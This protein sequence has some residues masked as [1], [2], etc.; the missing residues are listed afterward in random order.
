[1]KWSTLKGAG[2]NAERQRRQKA[3]K[4]QKT[5]RKSSVHKASARKSMRKLSHKKTHAGSFM[6][7]ITGT[8][9]DHRRLLLSMIADETAAMKS[10]NRPTSDQLTKIIHSMNPSIM[11][12]SILPNPEQYDQEVQDEQT[13]R[14]QLFKIM[15]LQIMELMIKESKKEMIDPQIQ[16]IESRINQVSVRTAN[17][18]RLPI[19]HRS[20]DHGSLLR[21]INRQR[22]QSGG[23]GPLA[24]AATAPM[25]AAMPM[26]QP[27]QT[28]P[29]F[30]ERV[31]LARPLGE[32]YPQM[33]SYAT[34]TKTANYVIPSNIKISPQSTP[35]DFYEEEQATQAAP[36]AR[37]SSDRMLNAAHPEVKAVQLLKGI[38]EISKPSSTLS[39]TQKTLLTWV[40]QFYQATGLS[41]PYH[42]FKPIDPIVTDIMKN[43][44]GFIRQHLENLKRKLAIHSPERFEVLQYN[45]F[46]NILHHIRVGHT[47][48]V[49]EMPRDKL[50]GRKKLIDPNE[51]KKAIIDL[52]NYN[53]QYDKIYV[54]VERK[55]PTTVQR[56]GAPLFGESINYVI[57]KIYVLYTK[58]SGNDM[59][60]YYIPCDPSQFDNDFIPFA[61]RFMWSSEQVLNIHDVM[62]SVEGY[63]TLE[64]TFSGF[65]NPNIPTA[66]IL[67][68]L[69]GTDQIT[70]D[71]IADVGKFTQLAI[72]L[73]H[74]RYSDYLVST[75]DHV[76]QDP[77][78]ALELRE[79]SNAL[80]DAIAKHAAD[81]QVWSGNTADEL[82]TLAAN[83]AVTAGKLDLTLKE[84]RAV[85]E[86][87]HNMTHKF[88]GALKD[89][90][91]GV[92]EAAE[93]F[94]GTV[95]G[96]TKSA[97]EMVRNF[98]RTET[99]TMFMFLYLQYFNSMGLMLSFG[100]AGVA[101]LFPAGIVTTAVVAAEQA[102]K[103]MTFQYVQPG[104]STSIL[105]LFL[106]YT[107]YDKSKTAS[108][109]ATMKELIQMCRGTAVGQ[110]LR[111]KRR[112][113][114][115]AS[116]VKS[117][118]PTKNASTNQVASF[119]KSIS[120]QTPR[121]SRFSAAPVITSQAALEATRRAALLKNAENRGALKGYSTQGG[122]RRSTRKIK[123][124]NK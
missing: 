105:L 121:K 11:I 87:F 109:V 7:N 31:Q 64:P 69:Q 100:T 28:Q 80:Q 91:D 15:L 20:I 119:V 25:A 56:L 75:L 50:H 120:V 27:G 92:A 5:A 85:T 49:N 115:M 71:I 103:E 21:I 33:A 30:S 9:Q 8:E 17:G 114:P 40:D 51:I 118:S 74:L 98:L 37:V 123:R 97:N 99:L 106:I 10:A 84:D 86:F 76:V 104:W 117:A 6:T 47:K 1:M 113:G 38:S 12:G 82:V 67:A 29:I 3:A 62:K 116:P 60:D 77:S 57:D 95:R 102:V 122:R 18:F 81:I 19:D 108:A 22:R 16:L 72:Q 88:G 96:I 24:Q 65:W 73:T 53:S 94:G 63:L 70:K 61:F 44:F 68:K 46:V 66:S 32:V 107:M 54:Y 59:V 79:Q 14:S 58:T 13:V 4:A 26:F 101:P 2:K 39:A 78:K 93:F 35:Y 111:P 45:S 36:I 34:G 55:S 52:A 112:F 43:K 89:T 124:T 83:M 90:I 110:P 42:P 23:M 48:L 41:L